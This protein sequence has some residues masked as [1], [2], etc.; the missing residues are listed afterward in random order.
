MYFELTKHFKPERLQE[1]EKEELISEV[2]SEA[3]IVLSFKNERFILQQHNQNGTIVFSNGVETGSGIFFPFFT[4]IS[5]ALKELEELIN[6]SDVTEDD[7]QKLLE[8]YPDL[9]LDSDYQKTIP[10]ARI[11]VEDTSWEADFVLVPFNQHDFCKILELKLPKER[12][13]SKET[14]GHMRL[15]SKLYHS[16]Q[17]IQDYHNAF[18]SKDTRCHFFERYG[19][20]VYRPELQLIIGRRGE[21]QLKKNFIDKQRKLN[22]KIV[23]WD[24]FLEKA[25]RRF[26]VK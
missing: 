2:L 1:F 6:T 18:N 25:K 17:Q 4:T 21:M 7:I 3:Y 11:V 22:I 19:T 13:F 26:D 15:S 23:D 5:A 20:D 12:L 14:N 9:I 16:L 8:R 24:S 10:Q